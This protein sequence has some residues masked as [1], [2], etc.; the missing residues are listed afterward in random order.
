MDI[1]TES[2]IKIETGL[3]LYA[4]YPRILN[5]VMQRGA[6]VAPR[7]QATYEVSPLLFVLENPRDCIKLQRRRRI[8]YAYA[9]IEKLSLIYGQADPET[10]QFYIPA[11][12]SLLDEEGKFGGAYGPRLTHQLDYVYQL[13]KD[14]PE[15]RRAVMTVFS[16]H[17]DQQPGEDIP[18]TVSLQFLLR[19]GRLSMITNMRSSDVYLGLPYDVQQFTFLQQLLAHWLNVGLGNYTHIAGSGHIYLKDLNAVQEV[20]DEPDH[21]NSEAEPPVDLTYHQARPQVLAFFTAEKEL[22]HGDVWEPTAASTYAQL[23]PYL[24]SCLRKVSRF[25]HTR[26]EPTIQFRATPSS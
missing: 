14:D 15:S 4:L 8:N 16:A 7:H 20:I 22:R 3:S 23:G 10:F 11:L 1:I 13:L 25:I 2:S 26:A 5:D 21:L 18:C 17:S 19:D 24:R 6:P 12:G 9:I